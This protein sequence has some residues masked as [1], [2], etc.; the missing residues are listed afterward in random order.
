M[1]FLASYVYGMMNDDYYFMHVFM[2]YFIIVVVALVLFRF[3]AQAIDMQDFQD[4]TNTAA[5]VFSES[6]KQYSVDEALKSSGN[7]TVN[8]KQVDCG[9][10]WDRFGGMFIGIWVAAAVVSIAVGGFWIWMLIDC[11]KRDFKDKLVWI[12]VL[13]VG[14]GFGAILYYFMVKKSAQS[15]PVQPSQPMTLVP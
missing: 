14:Q 15:K 6:N 2:K 11:A 8:G 5:Q 7:C 4:T 10:F 9:E 1:I 3:P 12:I 13:L